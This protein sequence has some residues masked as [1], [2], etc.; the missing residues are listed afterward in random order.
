MKG[1]DEAAM[2]PF[3]KV[4]SVSPPCHA[5]VTLLMKE[6]Y[7]PTSAHVKL[8]CDFVL[9]RISQSRTSVGVRILF[10]K[11]HG[12]PENHKVLYDYGKKYSDSIESIYCWCRGKYVKDLFTFRI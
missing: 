2:S 7:D 4:P 10:M 3:Q 12:E 8:Q 5:K 11:C 1:D 9:D 6:F